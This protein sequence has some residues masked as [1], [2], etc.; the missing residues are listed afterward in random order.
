MIENDILNEADDD[1][2]YL[3]GK[4]IPH[5]EARVDEESYN[6]WRVIYAT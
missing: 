2:E 5:L 4:F 3:K 1:A 6:H